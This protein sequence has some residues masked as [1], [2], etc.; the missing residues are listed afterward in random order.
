MFYSV[1]STLPAPTVVKDLLGL[2]G[3]NEGESPLS[4]NGQVT[5]ALG[6]YLTAIYFGQQ[7]MKDRKPFKLANLFM[8]HNVILSLGSGVLLAVMLE[9]LLP[10]IAKEGLFGSICNTDAWTSRMEQFYIINYYFKYAELADTAFLVLKK[11]PLQFLHVFHHANTALLCYVQLNGRTSV[12]WVPIVLNLTVHVLMYY[13]YFA[14]T[15]GMKIWWKKYL[16]TMQ[17]TQFVIDLFVVV[18]Y[19]LFVSRYF[20]RT[21]PFCGSCAGT[22]RAAIFGCSLLTSYLFLFIAFYKKTY[23]AKKAAPQAAVAA[24]PSPASKAVKSS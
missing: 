13:Y 9:E 1:L 11:K 5:L 8:A 21:L 3:W 6:S 12:S 18:T 20:S 10:I 15:A 22:K 14:T 16:T 4:T 17:I 19:N 7:F 24:K 2:N 23:N